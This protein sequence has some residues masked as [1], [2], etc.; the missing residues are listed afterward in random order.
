MQITRAITFPL[1]PPDGMD[2]PEFWKLLHESWERSTAL[3]NWTV[4]ALALQDAVRLGSQKLPPFPKNFQIYAHFNKQCPDRGLWDGMTQ[5][6]SSVLRA[7]Q[8]TYFAKRFEVLVRREAKWMHYRYPYPFLVQNAAWKILWDGERPRIR[9]ALPG[10]TV[11]VNVRCGPEMR[12]QLRQLRLIHEG[13]AKQG[14]LSLY[15]KG[16]HPMLKAVGTF[17]V[18]DQP[19]AEHTMLVRT[20]PQAFWV[21]ELDFSERKEPWILNADFLRRKVAEHKVFLQR[22]S[23]DTKREKRWPASVREEMNRARAKRCRKQEARVSSWIHQ[24]TAMLVNFA[25]RRKV[26]ILIYDDKNQEYLDSFPW[27]RLK[28]TL[29]GKCQAIDMEFKDVN[30]PKKRGKKG[31]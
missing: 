3:A 21:G 31:A 23:E 26:K 28:V 13:K 4:Q 30:P 15:V 16:N 18:Q 1:Y 20:D 29:A 14:E 10:G 8:K 25:R 17:E 19:D 2:W 12:R 11:E 27:S 7:V 22:M 5:S 24:A 9:A 6:A